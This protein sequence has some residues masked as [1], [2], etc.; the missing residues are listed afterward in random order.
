[1]FLIVFLR[2]LPFAIGVLSLALAWFSWSFGSPP[3]YTIF[4]PRQPA[5]VV[6]ARIDSKVVSSGRRRFTPVVE[7][8]T[9]N[10]GGAPQPLAGVM[11]AFTSGSRQQ[12]EAAIKP[13]PK[14][15]TVRVRVA[16][17]TLYADRTEHF[18]L[19]HAAFLTL[20]G[21]AFAVLGALILIPASMRRMLFGGLRR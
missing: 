3:T 16:R 13:Y 1:M 15:A 20:V 21:I 9:E 12:A 18:N 14:G 17:G 5:T 7:V 2:V 11:P 19:Y 4:S 8:F 6:E 10:G